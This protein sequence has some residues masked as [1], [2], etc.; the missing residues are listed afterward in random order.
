M[1]NLKD[2]LE[3]NDM[4]QKAFAEKIGV[5]ESTVSN[6]VTGKTEPSM[7]DLIRAATLFKVSIDKLIGMEI[8]R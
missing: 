5:T 3:D 7:S 6:W 2:I 1:K 4:T 8:L